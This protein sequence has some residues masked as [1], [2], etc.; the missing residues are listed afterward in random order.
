MQGPVG[1]C[2]IR[3]LQ[4]RFAE[5]T[6]CLGQCCDELKADADG[7]GVA[8]AEDRR[9]QWLRRLQAQ[10]GVGSGGAVAAK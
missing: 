5:V 6:E 9:Q 8:V 4:V 1:A 2:K 10:G 3:Q 7:M